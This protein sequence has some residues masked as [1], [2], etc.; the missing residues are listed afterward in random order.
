MPGKIPATQPIRTKKLSLYI[1]YEGN[2][3]FL[4]GRRTEKNAKGKFVTREEFLKLGCLWPTRVAKTREEFASLLGETI[5]DEVF[6]PVYTIPA[7]LAVNAK[8]RLTKAFKLDEDDDENQE[9]AWETDA[10]EALEHFIATGKIDR[11]AKVV[12]FSDENDPNGMPFHVDSLSALGSVLYEI[13]ATGWG[14][15]APRDSG[16]W[17]FDWNDVYTTYV[18]NAMERR[19]DIT[20]FLEL[21]DKATRDLAH[22]IIGSAQT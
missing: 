3:P 7:N 18:E 16:E 21:R 12:H 4:V 9:M 14:N 1:M 20:K 11:E 5:L 6:P 13:G 22:A 17:V 15:S 19:P 2:H 10:R 8:A